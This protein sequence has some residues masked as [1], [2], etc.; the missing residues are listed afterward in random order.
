MKSTQTPKMG[1]LNN[2]KMGYLNNPKMGY[3]N[4]N[5]V[6]LVLIRIISRR[7]GVAQLDELMAV[8]LMV[9]SSNHD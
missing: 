2:P 4:N 6:V 5:S 3:L 7:V 8:N 1:Y 9:M